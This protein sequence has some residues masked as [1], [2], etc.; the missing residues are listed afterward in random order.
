MKHRRVVS[1]ALAFAIVVLAS[2]I[3]GWMLG[4]RP[5]QPQRS[6]SVVCSADET[7]VVRNPTTVTGD[8]AYGCLLIDAN[9]TFTGNVIVE[10]L[11]WIGPAAQTI[12]FYGSFTNEG[13]AVSGAMP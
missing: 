12:T 5:T 3:A 11:L 8:R 10:K 6:A 13:V 1:L 9:V 7:F 4:P 2:F